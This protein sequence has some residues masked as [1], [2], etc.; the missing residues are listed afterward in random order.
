MRYFLKSLAVAGGFIV[1]GCASTLPDS[2][3]AAA[4]ARA[5]LSVQQAGQGVP[6]VIDT[7]RMAS[8]QR[9][10]TDAQLAAQK[11]DSLRAVRLA[12]QSE[13][14]AQVAAAN[15]RAS[16]AKV[17]ADEVRAGVNTL[18]RETANPVDTGAVPSSQP[19][20]Q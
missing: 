2:E 5:Q 10:L 13:V 19:A 16:A 7:A 14:D 20:N 12:Q 15:S 17:S 11:H 18:Q 9:K 4:I 1:G 3:T 8:A 6:G